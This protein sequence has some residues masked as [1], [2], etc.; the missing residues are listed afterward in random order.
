MSSGRE[1][2]MLFRKVDS[3]WPV[4]TASH[5]ARG[6]TKRFARGSLLDSKINT[7]YHIL[8]R[9]NIVCPEDTIQT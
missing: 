1:Q 6:F 3:Y 2:P 8:P 5:P 4:Y 7:D 9:V